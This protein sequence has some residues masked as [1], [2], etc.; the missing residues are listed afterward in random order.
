MLVFCAPVT[1]G[2]SIC[3]G[4]ASEQK[5]QLNMLLHAL[6]MQLRRDQAVTKILHI[7]KARVPILK[8]G[9]TAPHAL[10]CPHEW[11]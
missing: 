4:Y 8:V 2:G 9:H 7:R 5:P 6:M 11:A 1:V 10:Q 3:A